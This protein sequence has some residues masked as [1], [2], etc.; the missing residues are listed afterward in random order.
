MAK[1][2]LTDKEKADLRYMDWDDASVGRAVK[3][4]A[5]TLYGDITHEQ[6]GPVMQFTAASLVLI[7]IAHTSNAEISEITQEGVTVKG[8]PVGDYKVTVEKINAGGNP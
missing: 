2:I 4:I 3:K 8:V 5:S 7:N 1:L 6:E